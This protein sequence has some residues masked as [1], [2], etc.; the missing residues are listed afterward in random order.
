VRTTGLDGKLHFCTGAHEQKARNIEANANCAV[1]TGTNSYR[2]GLDVVVEGAAQR[3]TDAGTLA[4][5]A[6]M[7]KDKIDWVF[8][9]GDGVFLDPDAAG[10]SAQVFAVTPSK[11][12]AFRKA[13]YSQTRYIM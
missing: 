3:V 1:T 8:E 11:V 5:L 2:S 6:S 12:L 4:R 9:V 13:P 7:W 10:H